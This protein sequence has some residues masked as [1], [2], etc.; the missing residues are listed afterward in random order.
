MTTPTTPPPDGLELPCISCGMAES[1]HTSEDGAELC[2]GCWDDWVAE[3]AACDHDRNPD[4]VCIE[5]GGR[6]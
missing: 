2:A 1:A 5:C 4:G 3:I 6:L